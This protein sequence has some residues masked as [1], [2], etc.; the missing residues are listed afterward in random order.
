MKKRIVIAGFGDTGLLTAIHLGNNYDIVGVSTKPCLV[1]GQELGTRL[2]QPSVWKQDYLMQFSRYK[3]LHNV[4]TL[5]G[6][7]SEIDPGSNAVRIDLASG[8]T[9]SEQY[10]VLVLCPGTSNGF[11]RN[12]K[13]ESLTDI[14]HAISQQAQTMA[15]AECLAVVGGGPSGVSVASNMALRHPHKD[16]HLFYSQELPVPGYHAKAR[17]Q[18]TDT[19]QLQGVHLHPG[20][21]A[22]IPNGFLCDQITPGPIEWQ[23]GQLPFEADAV[24]WA[25]GKVRPNTGF[26]PAEMLDEHGFINADKYLRVPGYTNIFTLGDAAATDTNRSSARN[27]GYRLAAN[28][29]RASLN[30]EPESMKSY[31]APEN[32]WGSILGVQDDGLR[33]FQ[34][35]GGSFRFPRWSVRHLLFP[36]AVRRGIYRGVHKRVR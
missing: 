28:N 21:R 2:S 12:D 1:S 36:L 13:V 26:I 10:D 29:I 34:P 23:S 7:V 35:N 30:G 27:W 20:H 11:W 31:E 15:K 17:Q 3:K 5:Q 9:R 32:R 19:L 24:L 16:V 4:T 33:V 18:V 25:V 22:A 14:E 6:K 8:E